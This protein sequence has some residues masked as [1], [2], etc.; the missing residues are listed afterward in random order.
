MISAGCRREDM[1]DK[2]AGGNWKG[3]YEVKVAKDVGKGRRR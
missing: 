2:A 1:S 3:G